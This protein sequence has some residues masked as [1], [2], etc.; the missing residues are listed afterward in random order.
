MF[1]SKMYAI[2]LK[3]QTLVDI[4]VNNQVNLINVNAG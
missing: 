3:K 4:V 2:L 1:L